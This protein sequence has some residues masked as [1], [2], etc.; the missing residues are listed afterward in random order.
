[1]PGALRLG[2][3]RGRIKALLPDTATVW[4][5]TLTADGGGGFNTTEAAVATV[6]CRL[7][8]LAI[9]AR[10][11]QETQQ[12]GRVVATTVYQAYLPAGTD[13]GPADQLE[14]FAR[15]VTSQGRFE[16]IDD[17]SARSDGAVL[18]VNLRQVV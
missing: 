8:A 9:S 7:D 4:R 12:A 3:A 10:L 11:G 5:K 1:M 14:V 15:G 13:C 2:F 17:D 16:I 18:A 6:A